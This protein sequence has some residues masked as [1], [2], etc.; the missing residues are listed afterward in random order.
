MQQRGLALLTSILAFGN[1]AHFKN[2]G[3]HSIQVNN[4]WATSTNNSQSIIGSGCLVEMVV[5]TF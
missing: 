2:Y 5:E 4:Q 1:I 3:T